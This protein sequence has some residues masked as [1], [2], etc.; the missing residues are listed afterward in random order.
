MPISDHNPSRDFDLESK[1]QDLDLNRDLDLTLLTPLTLDAELTPVF[2]EFADAFDAY[3]ERRRKQEEM[4]R[5]P[6]Q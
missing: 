6:K 4:Q 1:D 5:S 2:Q 3:W